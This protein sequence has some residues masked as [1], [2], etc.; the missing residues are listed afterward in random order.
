[1]LLLFGKLKFKKCT[2]YSF[3][4]LKTFALFL[5][6][7]FVSV[8][9]HLEWFYNCFH[10]LFIPL[11]IMRIKSNM[12]RVKVFKKVIY[13][14]NIYH[15]YTFLLLGIRW[16]LFSDD[17]FH[18]YLFQHLLTSLVRLTF[19]DCHLWFCT[20]FRFHPIHTESKKKMKNKIYTLFFGRSFIYITVHSFRFR[21][22]FLYLLWRE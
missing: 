8:S 6:F 9:L 17:H 11:L 14:I 15:L 10:L 3:D 19:R 21:R 1:M 5:P 7:D 2:Q 20:Y 16:I 4:L 22:C 12:N 18:C 13:I